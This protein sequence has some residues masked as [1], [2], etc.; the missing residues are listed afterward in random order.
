MTSSS[1]TGCRSRNG[2]RTRAAVVA[3]VALAAAAAETAAGSAPA[4]AATTTLAVPCS[5][6]GLVSAMTSVA[7]T[8]GKLSLAS[9]CTYALTAPADP[10]DGATGLPVV[11]AAVTIVGNRA[12]ITRSTA[13]GTP[14]FR[15]FDVAQGGTLTISGVTLSNGLAPAATTPEVGWGGGAV[16]SHGTL[17]VSR[18]T[19]KGNAA[20]SHSGTSGGAIDSAGRLSVANSVFTGN[21]AQEG[22]AIF[23]QNTTWITKST[24]DGNTATDYGGGAI[25][26]AAGTTTINASTFANNVAVDTGTPPDGYT[27][28]GGAI[29]NDAYVY[30]RNSTFFHNA[31]GSNGGGA[32]QNFGTA[33]VT[34]S[35]LS[36]NTSAVSGSDIHTYADP[37]APVP[38]V[39]KIAR[40][41]LGSGGT[42][43]GG[44]APVVDN[45]FNIDAGTS[46]GLSATK[47]S[48]SNTAVQL[49]AL[50]SNGGPTQTMALQPGSPAVDAIPTSA[51]SCT[52]TTD[53]RGTARPQG[54]GCD[55]GAYEL[56]SV[57]AQ[58]ATTLS[59]HVRTGHPDRFTATLTYSATTGP[60]A[61]RQ[62]AVYYHYAPSKR[63]LLQQTL[64]T[65][66]QGKVYFTEQPGRRCGYIVRFAGTN[67][68]LAS[69]SRPISV[70]Y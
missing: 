9:G 70:A 61:G 28:G 42:N 47:G 30:V 49:G 55:I 16:N 13:S 35:T 19:F 40:S 31:G 25:V 37:S 15:L 10:T 67:T 24:F 43:C 34:S 68:E 2:T 51:G 5:T 18:V 64:T 46:C 52:G 26:S 62:L 1:S 56:K 54:T 63:W 23:A 65:D 53:Q 57:A 58:A 3:A 33:V 20:P 66:A 11:T 7:S 38:V 60:V 39:T 32:I 21:Q 8:G 48:L 4:G 44:N 45:G 50:A 12:T 17:H 29:D 6:A 27:L 59:L 36:G 14:S 69:S 41:I 22:G